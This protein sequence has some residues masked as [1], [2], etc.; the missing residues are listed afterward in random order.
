[1]IE[2]VKTSLG[3]PLEE[4]YTTQNFYPKFTL[5]MIYHNLILFIILKNVSLSLEIVIHHSGSKILRKVLR[6]VTFLFPLRIGFQFLPH[7]MR[8][9]HGGAKARLL[10]AFVRVSKWTNVFEVCRKNNLVPIIKFCSFNLFFFFFFER[11]SF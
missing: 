8:S 2:G 4:C 1:M 7:F 6:S 5:Q 3:F 10:V 9:S 11:K